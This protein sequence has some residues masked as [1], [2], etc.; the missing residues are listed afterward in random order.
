MGLLDDTRECREIRCILHFLC[1]DFHRLYPEFFVRDFMLCYIITLKS[2]KPIDA[3]NE[4]S[5][6]GHGRPHIVP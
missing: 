5:R 6:Q 1:S 3:G 2:G 4:P